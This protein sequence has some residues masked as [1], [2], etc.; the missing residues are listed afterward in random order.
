MVGHECNILCW[1]LIEKKNLCLHLSIQKSLFH[2]FMTIIIFSISLLVSHNHSFFSITSL[3]YC[4]LSTW[5]LYLFFATTPL[6]FQID[7]ASFSCWGILS[8]HLPLS[9]LSD[10]IRKVDIYPIYLCASL[11]L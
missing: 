7:E 5:L 6:S 2:Y 10:S 1:V 4:K 8:N 3:G 9:T 11:F